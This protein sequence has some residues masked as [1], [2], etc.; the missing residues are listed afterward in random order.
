[1]AD[2]EGYSA[3]RGNKYQLTLTNAG[4]TASRRILSLL[5]VLTLRDEELFGGNC[6]ILLLWWWWLDES[7]L[8]GKYL[9][10]IART[11]FWLALSSM[12]EYNEL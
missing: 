12:S 6:E 2:L 11:V 10:S 3:V 1:M 7:I 8:C 5:S 4:T 9:E